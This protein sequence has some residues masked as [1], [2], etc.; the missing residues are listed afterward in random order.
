MESTTITIGNE[1]DTRVYRY[2][3]APTGKVV[4]IAVGTNTFNDITNDLRVVGFTMT[5]HD[6]GP[7]MVSAIDY[8][9]DDLFDD[10]TMIVGSY[11]IFRS[12]DSAYAVNLKVNDVE[13]DYVPKHR[14]EGIAS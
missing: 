7:I 13:P 4:G 2:R 3:I 9:L 12:F 11:P 1:H 5:H 8:T 6:R 10:G 14:R